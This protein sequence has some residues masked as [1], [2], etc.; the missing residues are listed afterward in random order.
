MMNHIAYMLIALQPLA[1][2]DAE[3]FAAPVA[4]DLRIAAVEQVGKP[5]YTPRDGRVYRLGG[6]AISDVRLG[7]ILIIR[8]Q[9]EVRDL[10]LLRVVSLHTENFFTNSALAKLESKGET[11]PIKGDV[12]TKLMP[13]QMPEI[14]KADTKTLKEGIPHAL[15]P[16]VMPGIQGPPTA[17]SKTPP[18]MLP[19]LSAPAVPRRATGQWSPKGMPVR[20]AL[21]PGTPN[22]LEQNPIY[23]VKG[24]AELSPM[25]VVRL[26][27]WTGAWG[28][29][30][31]RYFLAVPQNQLHMQR[32]TLERLAVLQKE[33]Q[34]LGISNIELRTDA[35]GDSGSYDV[36]YVGV[37][38]QAR[39][40]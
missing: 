32:L 29:S 11:F 37:E 14:K 33:L 28:R 6:D 23:F 40:L 39:V 26:K 7:E 16:L 3:P 19:I 1:L 34:R 20:P 12:A 15:N 9:G 21:P 38:G 31:L 10:G 2:P 4:K 13:T 36:V 24:S 17:T 35:K 5:P 18:P 30:G 8:R 27:E 22:L 25:G